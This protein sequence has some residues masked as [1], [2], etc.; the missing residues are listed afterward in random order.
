M[1]CFPF[2]LG[3]QT[4]KLSLTLQEAAELMN[5]RNLTMKLADKAMGISRGERQKPN[6]F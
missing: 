1:L 2:A 6:A 3:A 5:R 4:G